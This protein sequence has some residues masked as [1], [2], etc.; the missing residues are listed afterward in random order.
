VLVY[1]QDGDSPLILASCEGHLLIVDILLRNGANVH[2]R[3]KV[4]YYA[5]IA[6]QSDMQGRHAKCY[7]YSGRL[8]RCRGPVFM[9]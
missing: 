8:L 7:L 5:I 2:A 4:M 9:D 3:G 6:Y 1:L